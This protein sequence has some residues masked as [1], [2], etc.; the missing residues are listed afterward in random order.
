MSAAPSPSHAD[1]LERGV[2]DALRAV[3]DPEIGLDVVTLGLVY[4]IE[5]DGG[6]VAVVYTLTTPGCPMEAIITQAIVH[7]ARAVPGVEVVEPRLVWDPPWRPGM[8]E[9]GAW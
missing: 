4:G 3:I 9:D 2:R 1:C 8:I 5:V 6:D 7:A